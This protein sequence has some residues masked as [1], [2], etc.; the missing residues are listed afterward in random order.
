MSESTDT[1]QEYPP[2]PPP[3]NETAT[4][5]AGLYQ[6]EKTDA[7]YVLNTAMVMMGIA[8][9]YLIG[10]I[11]FV[12]GLSHGHG[13]NPWLYLPLLPFPLWLIIA[14]HSLMTTNAMCHGISVRIIEDALYKAAALPDDVRD[15]VGSAPGDRIMDVTQAKRIHIVTSFVV[16]IGVACLVLGFTGYC[17]F[18]AY[19]VIDHGACTHLLVFWIGVIVYVALLIMVYWSWIEGQRIIKAGRARIPQ[20]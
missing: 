17:L 19:G 10:A 18:S 4:A 9:A 2:T 8:V 3:N 14:Y 20:I 12:E 15:L 5:L 11:P 1:N 7:S 16:Y 13:T 6:G